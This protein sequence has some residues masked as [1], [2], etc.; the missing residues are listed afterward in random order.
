MISAPPTLAS[1]PVVFTQTKRACANR[2]L[3]YSVCR[4]E[5]GKQDKG[6]GRHSSWKMVGDGLMLGLAILEFY[7]ITH[8]S[9]PGHVTIKMNMTKRSIWVPDR[10][11]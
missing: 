7:N 11:R 1:V 2:D 10:W 5:D 6:P 9:C 8:P 4:E 3:E